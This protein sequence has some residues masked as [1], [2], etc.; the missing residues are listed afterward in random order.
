MTRMTII[1]KDQSQIKAGTR[2]AIR[3]KQHEKDKDAI[4]VYDP[5][6]GLEL[7]FVANSAT[8]VAGG[9][10]GA[11]MLRHEFDET[12][13]IEVSEFIEKRNGIFYYY[14]ADS[15]KAE[16]K[17]VVKFVLAGGST[18]YPGK[19]KLM[20]D[21]KEGSV[22]VNLRMMGDKIVGFYEGAPSGTVKTDEESFNILQQYIEDTPEV[23]VET[24]SVER[25][26]IVC[27][28]KIKLQ[29]K[30][31]TRRTKLEESMKRIISE[32]INTQENLDDKL[33]YL[34]R[35]KVTTASI[36]ALFE[37]YT[38]YPDSVAA[39]IPEKPEVLY[40]DDSGLV[41][42]SIAFINVG[43]NLRFE[44]EKGVGKNVLTETLCWL[45][46]RPLYEFSSNSQQSNNSLLGGKTFES[47]DE[48]SEEEKKETVW[49]F[50]SL[51]K[52]F[53]KVLFK[54][55]KA[56]VEAAEID[57]A[58]QAVMKFLGKEDKKLVFEMSSILE[59]FINGGIIVLDE[60]N[61]SLAHVMPVFNSLLDDRRRMEITGYGRAVGHKNFVAIS[62]MN[63][64]Y[65]GTFEG[66]EATMDR[67]VPILFPSLTTITPI[68]QEKVKSLNYETAV[69]ANNIY[70]RLRD[71]VVAGELS[72]QVLSIRGF[73]NACKVLQEGI[74]LKE[75]LIIS[76]V[77]AIGD[78]DERNA[79]KE[80]I[81]LKL[82]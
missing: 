62:T 17:D 79:V 12:L 15:I 71:A 75:A 65:E 21:A 57:S 64:N 80:M 58:K 14:Y 46:N 42:S 66:N 39:R 10:V 20:K 54:G 30:I 63:R 16:Q 23:M 9:S 50:L 33:E 76:V 40:V 73:I 59:A 53:K 35:C 32:G 6:S 7:G 74:S 78:T 5:T 52:L 47:V 31:E 38:K 48:I 28:L 27:A 49:S 29:A 69:A 61:T 34:N 1:L 70:L 4:S 41:K 56:D 72:T 2:L 55:E 81:E 67:F 60:F 44:G 18:T 13:D 45:Y 26:E 3:K 51:G 22:S 68:L 11:T 36:A 43:S 77:N 19:M 24:T 25:A 37:S 8:T 82:L